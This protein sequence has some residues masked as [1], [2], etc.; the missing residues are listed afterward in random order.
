MSNRFIKVND[1]LHYKVN[2]ETGELEEVFVNVAMDN[3]SWYMTYFSCFSAYIKLT[4]CQKDLLMALCIL[5]NYST[6][7]PEGNV[8]SNNK[9]LKNKIREMGLN[10]TD[11]QI[12]NEI[13]RLAKIN[14]LQ[15]LERGTYMLNPE[16]FWKGTMSDRTKLLLNVSNGILPNTNFNG[17]N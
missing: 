16:Y 8:F 1:G 12:N 3:K 10:W 15:K 6:S 13:S 5:S 17:N 14:M 7:I 11:G 4:G 2:T 9:Y